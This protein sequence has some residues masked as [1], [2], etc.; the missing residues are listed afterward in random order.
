[1][2]TYYRIGRSR[3][4]GSGPRRGRT[5]LLLL[6]LTSFLAATAPLFG[7]EG[8]DRDEERFFP[9]V[10]SFVPGISIPFGGPYST[11]LGIGMLLNEVDN[12]Y[13]V[14]TA[15]II[16]IAS[17]D[18]LGLQANGVGSVVGGATTG[19]QT[20]GVFNT[21][22]G[23]VVGGQFAG[24]FN[25]AADDV[26]GIQ[27]AGVFNVAE[28]DVFFLQA[29]GVF[30]VAKDVTGA[31]VAG[32]FNVAE[33]VRGVQIGLVNISDTMYG[34]PIG[35]INIVREGISSPSLWFDEAGR[36]W[37]G[38]QRGSSLVYGLVYAGGTGAELFGSPSRFIGGAGIGLRLGAARERRFYLDIDAS[39]KT[40]II[41][42]RLGEDLANRDLPGIPSLRATLGIRLLRRLSLIGGVY[43]D[44]RFSP[45]TEQELLFRSNALTA[46]FE[47]SGV[48]LYPT[49]FLGFSRK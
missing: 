42:G 27:N 34:V 21:A 40:E 4:T 36:S 6:L 15:P 31:Q 16:G 49:L 12:L 43:A 37:I 38:L 17:G 24:V 33:T 41:A 13:G 39:M 47:L 18:V 11:N 3:F 2:K 1:M 48:E 7:Q 23:R 45:G 20:A 10:F 32:V 22:E 28:G 19:F 29:A 9:V 46:S 8:R 30:N 14:Q 5:A 25:H 35:L 26:V 44:M